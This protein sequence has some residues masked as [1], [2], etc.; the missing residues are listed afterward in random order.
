MK[1]VATNLVNSLNGVNIGIMH[2]NEEEGGLVSHAVED[3]ALSR[4]SIIDA[5]NALN[6]GG[7]TPL[8]ESLYEAYLYMSG[9]RVDFGDGSVP[10]SREAAPN[11]GQY[12]TPINLSCQ[13]NHVVL[14]TDGEPTRDHSADSD[15]LGLIDAEGQ[16]FTGLVGGSCDAEVYP[17]GFSPDGGS[18]LDELAAFMVEADLSPIDGVQN[19]TT[20]TVGFLVDLP[21]LRET[22]ARG[23]GQYQTAEDTATLTTALTNI[24]TSVLD[25]QATFTAPSVSINTFNQTRNLN[26]IYLGMFRPSST[27]HWPGNLKK[28]RLR[29]SDSMIVDANDLPII[30]PATGFLADN[31]QD[32]WS[33]TNDGTDVVTGG[34][35]NAIPLARNVYT[36]LGDPNLTGTSNRINTSN[37]SD[38][39]LGTGNPSLPTAQEVIDFINGAD[40]ADDDQDGDVTEPRLQAR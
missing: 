23:G 5:I 14:L 15:I 26:D 12:N 28:F 39:L 13:K 22:A 8:T 31:V 2:F 32:F 38:S 27:S 29:P 7:W 21:I 24:L 18:C 6:D 25:T 37:L 19:V 17:A 35:A 9:G 34:A 20:H 10:A 33:A 16:S 40:V 3:V 11:G 1:G 30:D 4:A 36:Y